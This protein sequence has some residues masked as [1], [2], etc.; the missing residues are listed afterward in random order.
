MRGTEIAMTKTVI[1]LDDEA[2]ALAMA[3]YG[4][5]V[6]K[7]AVNRA[8]RD[9]AGRREAETDGLADWLQEVGKRLTEVD[10]RKN[11]WRQ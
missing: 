9:A 6:K 8:L 1:D 3:H 4:T 5:T 11:A 10:P 7:E 2:L